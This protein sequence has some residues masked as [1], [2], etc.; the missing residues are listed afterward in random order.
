[1]V[2]DCL[3]TTRETV[4]LHQNHQPKSCFGGSFCLCCFHVANAVKNGMI[5]RVKKRDLTMPFEVKGGRCG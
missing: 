4:R 3:R 5:N 1:M 2:G